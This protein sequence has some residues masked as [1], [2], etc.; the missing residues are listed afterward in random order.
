[1]KTKLLALAILFFTSFSLMAQITGTVKNS[2]TLAPIANQSV[3]LQGDSTSSI[4]MQTTTNAS[5][6]YTFN[7]IATGSSYYNVSTFDCNQASVSQTVYSTTATVDLLICVGNGGGPS[8]CVAVF[9]ANPDSLNANTIHFVDLSAGSPT[10][11]FWNFG[12]GTSST[13]QNPTHTYAGNG[14]YNVYLSISSAT[15]SDST[16]QMVAIGGSTT[17]QA[18]F[19][20]IPDSSNNMQIMFY[21]MSTGSPTSWAWDFG[22]GTTSTL[23]NP[24]HTYASNGSYTISLSISSANCSD[25]TSYPITVGGPAPCQSVF[26]YASSPAN[27]LN[28][29]F[30]DASTGSPTSWAWDFGDGSTSTAQNPSHTYASAGTYNVSLLIF[31]ANCQ[32]SSY[33]SVSVSNGTGTNFSVSGVVTA[34]NNN[35]DFGLVKL[36]QTS[37]TLVDSVSL[38][39]NGGYTFN[40]VAAGSYLLYAIPATNS[41][42]YATYAPTYYTNDILWSNATTLVI[43]ASQTNVNIDLAQITPV[44]GTGSVSGNLGTGSKGGVSG[45]VINLLMN[46]NPVASTTSDVSGDYHFNNLADGT[47]TIWVEIAG[48]TTTAIVVTLDASN[49]NSDN[50]DFVVTNSTVEPKTVSIDNSNKSLSIKTYPNPVENDLNIALNL[51]NSSRVNLEIFNLAGQLLVSENYDLHSGSQTLRINLNQLAKGTYILKITD[52]NN[53]HTQQLIN[54]IR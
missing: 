50:N 54:K 32:S 6:Q 35:L 30:T 39:S 23:Q 18:A 1:M 47:Y 34:G 14:S 15:C 24:V 36:Y 10:S 42:S 27:G 8:S 40:N 38:D 12:D 3:I 17:C 44:S 22:D 13:L 48:K 45:A 9:T 29:Q 43:S 52:S 16:T 33:Q 2:S 5:G 37:G 4:Y 28:I 31:G 49:P 25:S 51:E 21:D 11:W 53:A 41:T 20:S 19:Y 7:S 46:S 26:T